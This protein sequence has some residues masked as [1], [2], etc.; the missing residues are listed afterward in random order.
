VGIV[1]ES[2]EAVV[3]EYAMRFDF[4]ASNNEV[5]YEAV[6]SGLNILRRLG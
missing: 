5:E 2:P 6:I 4:K 1:V 3:A